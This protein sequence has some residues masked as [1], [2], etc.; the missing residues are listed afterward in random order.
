MSSKG[1]ED[2]FPEPSNTMLCKCCAF[3]R[4]LGPRASEERPLLGV[5]GLAHRGLCCAHKTECVREHDTLN[6]N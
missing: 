5:S 6:P 1:K 4:F 2:P 3:P